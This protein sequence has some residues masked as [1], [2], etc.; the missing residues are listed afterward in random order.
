MLLRI[1][2][3]LPPAVLI[4]IGDAMARPVTMGIDP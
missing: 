3:C 4:W 2:A 1:L